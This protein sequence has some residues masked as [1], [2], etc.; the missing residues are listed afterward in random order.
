MI[1]LAQKVTIAFESNDP[2]KKVLEK[3]S[4]LTL[5]IEKY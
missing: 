5:I 3:N 1:F 4:F 2:F